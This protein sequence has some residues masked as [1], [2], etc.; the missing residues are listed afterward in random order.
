MTISDR[1]SFVLRYHLSFFVATGTPVLCCLFFFFVLENRGRGRGDS[2]GV[3]VS[4][5]VYSTLKWILTF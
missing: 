1:T 5:I 4:Y 3:I 2:F